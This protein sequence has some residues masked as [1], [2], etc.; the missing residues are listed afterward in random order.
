MYAITDAQLTPGKQLLEAVGAALDGGAHWIQY[1]DKST[2]FDRRFSEA[3]QLRSLCHARGAGFIVND[4]LE[5]ALA[6]GAD[7]VHIGK[8]DLSLGLARARLGTHAV[9]GVS[10]YN[11]LDLA[12]SA[13]NAGADYLAFGSF[14]PSRTKPE[15]VRA[16]LDLLNTARTYDRPICAIGGINTENAS[17]VLESGAD[18][19]AVINAVFS[20]PDIKEASRQLAE[21]CEAYWAATE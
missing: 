3:R 1:R 7:G 4:D 20:A 9:I 18:M 10:C 21:L 12:L 11:S 16:S 15:A 5:L 2:D 17:L 8:D 6:C 13:K 19:I 14:F